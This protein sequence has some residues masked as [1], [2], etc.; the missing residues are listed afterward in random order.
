VTSIAASGSL[1]PRPTAPGAPIQAPA[2]PAMEPRHPPAKGRSRRR[3]ARGAAGTVRRTGREGSAAAMDHLWG[4]RP[5][6][7]EDIR[8]GGQS[9]SR[10]LPPPPHRQQQ[11]QG[12]SGEPWRFPPQ[13]RPPLP[14]PQPPQLHQVPPPPQRQQQAPLPPLPQQQQQA[15]PPPPEMPTVELPRWS[16]GMPA[17]GRRQ[18]PFF[19]TGW[20]VW[21]ST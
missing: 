7:P 21:S 16:P 15:P 11:P 20:G 3:L 19:Q 4:S 14:P 12:R 2:S 9:S 18:S 1:A 5:Q 6:A 13:L 8:V 17:S 10:A